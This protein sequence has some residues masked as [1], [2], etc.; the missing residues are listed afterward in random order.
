[1]LQSVAV[2]SEGIDEVLGALDRHFRYL[3]TS[4]ELRNRRRTRLRERVVEVTE[5]K[6]RQRLWSD[7]ATEAWVA[8][9]LPAMEA[10]TET[11]F[12]VADALLARSAALLS[13][14]QS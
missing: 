8:E 12:G 10:G 11:P 3:E 2:R 6:V 13:R 7:A 4:G 5:Q 14:T 1:V 9:R